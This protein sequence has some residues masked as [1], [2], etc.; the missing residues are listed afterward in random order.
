M[1]L[2][3]VLAAPCALATP[4]AVDSPDQTEGLILTLSDRYLDGD[5]AAAQPLGAGMRERANNASMAGQ[6]KRPVN[7]GC[8]VD[9]NPDTTLDNSIANRFV[10]ECNLQYRY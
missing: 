3:F 1:V 7:L 10:G 9:V 2:S 4:P 6:K 5:A 8:G